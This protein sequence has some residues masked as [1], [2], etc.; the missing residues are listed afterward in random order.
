MVWASK[1]ALV[2]AFE[3]ILF[4]WFLLLHYLS[5]LLVSYNTFSKSEKRMAIAFCLLSVFW[6]TTIHYETAG[7]F[8]WLLSRQA[9]A[10]SKTFYETIFSLLQRICC[11]RKQNK[12]F[13]NVTA[14]FQRKLHG[15]IHCRMHILT[16]NTV[17]YAKTSTH[18]VILNVVM[19]L[20][21][22]L[23]FEFLHTRNWDTFEAQASSNIKLN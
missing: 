11:S 8:D 2:N 22:S 21:M 13:D 16:L 17:L 18:I 7:I 3:W 1:N 15:D 5:S 19:L 14:L 10:I 12:N 6:D 23:F 9:R 20:L 4:N